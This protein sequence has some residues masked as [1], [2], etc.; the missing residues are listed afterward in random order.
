[1]NCVDKKSHAY[2][3]KEP[4]VSGKTVTIEFGASSRSL[5]E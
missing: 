3:G 4:F 2:W 5:L 1:M